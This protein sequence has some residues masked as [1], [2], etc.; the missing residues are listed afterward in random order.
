P[1]PRFDER[2]TIQASRFANSFFGRHACAE[3]SGTGVPT[4]GA[5]QSGSY[6]HLTGAYESGGPRAI[7]EAHASQWAVLCERPHFVP[8]TA[9]Y[10]SSP[11]NASPLAFPPDSRPISPDPR[12]NNACPPTL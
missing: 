11:P 8:P 1:R 10:R 3:R 2:P 12:P 5:E 9:P 7:A 6:P 4:V